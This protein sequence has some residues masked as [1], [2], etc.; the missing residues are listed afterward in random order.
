MKSVIKN[1]LVLFF[2][3]IVS[4]SATPSLK[5]IPP[6]QS[7]KVLFTQHRYLA[8]LPNPILSKGELLL[9]NGKG[10][11]WRT[12][13]PFPSTILITKK[14]LFQ[15]ENEN[16]NS[17]IQEGQEWVLLEM[18]SKLISGSFSEI[19]GFSTV[20]LPPLKGK[21][22]IRLSPTNAHLQNVLSSLDIEGGEYVSHVTIHRPN[23]DKDDIFL[24]NHLVFGERDT[25]KIF[26]PNELILF[27][28]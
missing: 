6:G 13:E 3:F 11:I 16:R 25:H 26:S 23:G 27:N 22:R 20:S 2:S 8:D 9:W 19:K 7:L 18:L 24:Q 15:V 14:G 5:N 1:C 4:A 12:Q 21:W 10:V 28:E 17:M